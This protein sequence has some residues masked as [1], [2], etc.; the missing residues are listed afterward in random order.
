MENDVSEVREYVEESGIIPGYSLK[1][2]GNEFT[3]KFRFFADE[4]GLIP[5]VNSPEYD[6]P[7]GFADAVQNTYSKPH[8]DNVKKDRNFYIDSVKETMSVSTSNMLYKAVAWGNKPVFMGAQA[9]NLQQIFDNAKDALSD[10]VS[11]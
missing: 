9:D 5:T 4:A 1:T 11:D 2:S 8:Y 10:I 3:I 7:D 6:A